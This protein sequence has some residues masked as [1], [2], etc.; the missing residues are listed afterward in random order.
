MKISWFWETFS[1]IR[2]MKKLEQLKELKVVFSGQLF[3]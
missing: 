3:G 2:A 1:V